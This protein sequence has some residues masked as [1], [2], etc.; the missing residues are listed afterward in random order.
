V[1]M[2]IRLVQE[3]QRRI[4]EFAQLNPSFECSLAV[5]LEELLKDRKEDAT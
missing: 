3:Y 2:S 1:N 5:R 4:E